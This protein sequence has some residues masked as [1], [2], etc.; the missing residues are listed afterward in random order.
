MIRNAG[1]LIGAEGHHSSC[2]KTI[3]KNLSP[4]VTPEHSVRHH[5]PNMLSQ[6]LG[7]ILVSASAATTVWIVM[8]TNRL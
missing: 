4:C 5:D 2:F 1:T 8:K 7:F 6:L 3:S